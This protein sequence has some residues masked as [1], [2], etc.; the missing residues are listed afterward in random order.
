M[1]KLVAFIFLFV[2]SFSLPTHAEP[3]VAE[4]FFIGVKD[5][6]PDEDE[7][8]I[9]A[10]ARVKY[11]LISDEHDLMKKDYTN[12]HSRPHTEIG[13]DLHAVFFDR[14]KL[15]ARPYFWVSKENKIAKIGLIGEIKWEIWEDHLE[16]G[17]GHHSWHN[18]DEEAPDGGRSQDWVMASFNLTG[19]L[20]IGKDDC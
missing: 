4:K 20:G 16:L 9:W 17:Y 18:A 11:F 1:K 13:I 5:F 6:L 12:S 10:D 7:F 14:L 8:Q 2:P 15:D 19:A 3:P